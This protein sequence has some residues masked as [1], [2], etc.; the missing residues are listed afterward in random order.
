MAEE[1]MVETTLS[2]DN[3][4]L[5]RCVLVTSIVFVLSFMIV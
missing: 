1:G 5:E 3:D 4:K 2:G